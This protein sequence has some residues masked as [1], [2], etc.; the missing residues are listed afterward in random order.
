MREKLG[1]F[2]AIPNLQVRILEM[3]NGSGFQEEISGVWLACPSIV[4]FI[5]WLYVRR[6]MPPQGLVFG[7][8]IHCA[9][10]RRIF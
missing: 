1:R 8:E 10:H 7:K 5:Q 6:K 2:I 3:L 4:A 9:Y